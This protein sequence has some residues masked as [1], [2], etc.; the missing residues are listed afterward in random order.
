V[1]NTVLVVDVIG[2]V[3]VIV[4]IIAIRD[5]HLPFGIPVR[6][7]LLLEAASLPLSD[8]SHRL[9]KAL[10][11]TFLSSKPVA[12]SAFAAPPRLLPLSLILH[13]APR[14]WCW[15]VMLILIVDADH[16][17]WSL[18]LMLIIDADRWCWCWSLIMMLIVYA[19]DDFDADR[20][21]LILIAGANHWF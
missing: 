4:L 21:S 14:C 15:S 19:G 9:I 20:W 11:L 17:C 18:M 12:R 8:S 10:S 1:T 5:P 16:W 13:L 6:K 3:V 7:A 2:I